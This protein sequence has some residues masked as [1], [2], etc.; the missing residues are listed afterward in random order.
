[1]IFTDV[2]VTIR[3]TTHFEEQPRRGASTG[4]SSWA[5]G[6]LWPRALCVTRVAGWRWTAGKLGCRS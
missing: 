2:D 4:A 3:P 1:M 6:W 5:V